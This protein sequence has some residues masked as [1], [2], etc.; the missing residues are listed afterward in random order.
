VRLN[1]DGSLDGSYTAQLYNENDNIGAVLAIAQQE[2]GKVVVGGYFNLADGSS[3]NEI[4][5]LNSDGSKDES[6]N[7]GFGFTPAGYNWGPATNDIKLD[8]DGNIYVA[9]A[10][11]DYNHA[12]RFQ[13]AKLDTNGVLQEWSVPVPYCQWGID[14]GM[15]DLYDGANY[16][17][18]NLTQP[19]L[20]IKCYGGDT[21]VSGGEGQCLNN[22]NQ[23][24]KSVPSTHTQAWYSGNVGDDFYDANGV[25][26]LAKYN[27]E[28]VNDG[29]VV[30]G[31]GYFGNGSQYFTAM[32]PGM[33]VLA[34]N[35]ISIDQF[36]ITGNIGSDGYGV[37]VAEV[38]PINAGGNNYTAYLKSNYGSDGSATDPSIN[39]IIIVDG[40]GIGI[41]QL[42]DPTSQGDEHCLTGL[43]GKTKLFYLMISKGCADDLNNTNCGRRMSPSEVQNIAAKFLEVVGL[44]SC[45]S[46]TYELN[47]SPDNPETIPNYAYDG[48][49]NMD[50]AVIVDPITG[51][52]RSIQRTGYFELT[53][54][55]GN[56]KVISAK[57]GEIVSS[58][59]NAWYNAVS[60]FVEPVVVVTTTPTP[61]AT[62]TPNPTPTPAP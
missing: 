31:S 14:D 27:Y 15:L 55:C 40:D 12:A 29:Q 16:L 21:I 33:F 9:G 10:F 41:E 36:S 38:Y 25:N 35:N 11:T 47:L 46:K 59:T 58:D 2:N 28:P 30:D 13:Y 34:A 7:S 45:V 20:D 62:A 26:N 4:F 17:N 48:E 18:T 51:K 44:G 3:A 8:L 6:F 50:T 56:R 1:S 19:Y 60:S 37:D 43:H 39:H 23:M 53:D 42:Y 54:N 24:D 32:F 61:T 49:G 22:D 57:D 5:R 52:R